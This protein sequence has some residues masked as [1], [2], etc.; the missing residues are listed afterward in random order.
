MV[1]QTTRRD[2]V[3]TTLREHWSELLLLGVAHLDLVGSVARDT[4]TTDSDVDLVADFSE[5]MDFVRFFDLTDRLE[6]LL[7]A[8]VDLMSRTSL[9]PHWRAHFDAEAVKVA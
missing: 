5:P 9:K 4:A 2:Q 1:S 8:H 6:A 3:L 7:G